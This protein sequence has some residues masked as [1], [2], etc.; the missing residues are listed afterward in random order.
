MNQRTDVIVRTVAGASIATTAHYKS[1]DTSHTGVAASNSIADIEY[2]ISHATYGW[3]V[4]VDV[5]ATLHGESAHCST[6]F[7]PEP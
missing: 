5:T 3:P 1:K 6:S 4:V 2:R 7:T